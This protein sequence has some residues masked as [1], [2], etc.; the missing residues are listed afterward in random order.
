MS[1]AA[2]GLGTWLDRL[3]PPGAGRRG[4]GGLPLVRGHLRQPPQ[5]P[6]RPGHRSGR[7]AAA[8]SR[9]AG[10]ADTADPLDAAEC[11]GGTV[12]VT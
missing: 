2:A 8:S 3:A 10:A 9:G 12:V 6:S 7:L 5:Q 4:G 11:R 1:G